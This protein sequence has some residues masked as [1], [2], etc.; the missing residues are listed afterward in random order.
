MNMKASIITKHLSVEQRILLYIYNKK[1]QPTTI[2]ELQKELDLPR[3]TIVDHLKLLEQDNLISKDKNGKIWNYY[4]IPQISE[5]IFT[6]LSQLKSAYVYALTQ[7]RENELKNLKEEA[8]RN[9]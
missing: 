8:R 7:I 9:E 5:K 1:S 2:E 3:T 4:P 6:A